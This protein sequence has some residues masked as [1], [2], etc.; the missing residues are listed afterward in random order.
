M[1]TND[2]SKMTDAELHFIAR[3]AAKA[4][5][6]LDL[7][8]DRAASKNLDR[9]LDAVSELRRRGYRPQGC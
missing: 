9:M 3:D 6:A 7:V 8:D 1:T 4:A 2:Y 5:N